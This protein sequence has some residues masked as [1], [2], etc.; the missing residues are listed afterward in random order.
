M[1]TM[2]YNLCLSMN[3]LQQT[4]SENLAWES[5]FIISLK[6]W[7]IIAMR[8]FEIPCVKFLTL[9]SPLMFL[10]LLPGLWNVFLIRRPAI[11][12]I[13]WFY[14]ESIDVFVLVF[15]LSHIRTNFNHHYNSILYLTLVI[16]N[17]Q[18]CVQAPLHSTTLD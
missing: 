5:R 13:P 3:F 18:K 6:S 1:A 14:G 7:M 9:P 12:T 17:S 16:K 10:V 11:S 15:L 4:F 2:V 8:K